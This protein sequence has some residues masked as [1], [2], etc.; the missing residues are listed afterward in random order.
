MT[1]IEIIDKIIQEDVSREVLVSS[2]EIVAIIRANSIEH[3]D[4]VLFESFKRPY[5]ILN[6]FRLCI[7][8]D[9]DNEP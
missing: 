9:V 4:F 3:A 2:E 7:S 5:Y 1:D 8:R 6:D